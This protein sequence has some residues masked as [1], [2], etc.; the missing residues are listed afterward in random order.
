MARNTWCER[1]GIICAVMG[2]A[3]SAAVA[4][5]D[6]LSAV[7]FDLLIPKP[8]E[9]VLSPGGC[10]LPASLGVENEFKDRRLDLQLVR[11]FPGRV[12]TSG[13]FL[14]IRKTAMP[15]GDEAYELRIASSGIQI[16]ASAPSGV[17]HALKTLEQLARSGSTVPCGTVRDWPSLPFRGV[18]LMACGL[19]TPSVEM[20]RTF[21]EEM[22]DLKFNKLVLECNERFPWKNSVTST[23][24]IEDLRSL[25]KL[26][27]DNF[28]E[29]IPLVNSLGH[30]EHLLRPESAAHVREQPENIGE[31]CP[32]N[33]ESLKFIKEM[34]GQVLPVF[35]ESAYA[36]Q[37]R[38]ITF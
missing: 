32:Q 4:G 25:V 29:V 2:L 21:V 33:P 5:Q 8:H 35:P 30:M 10:T 23:Y 38:S 1:L 13:G 36:C 19:F 27:E 9:V 34:W 7:G 31:M 28:I 14:K 16:D 26:A 17:F 18:H 20:L 11:T 37:R 12:I 3:W 24:T 15:R 6:K 22:A